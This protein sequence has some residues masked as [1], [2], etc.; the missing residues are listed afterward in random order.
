M[1]ARLLLLFALL[2]AAAGCTDNSDSDA[3]GSDG[4]DDARRAALATYARIAHAS[5][6]DALAGAE[7]LDRAVDA[8]LAAPTAGGLQTAR[9]AWRAAREP[10]G[11]TEAF[12]F[13]G[14]PIDAAGGPE[15]LLNAWPLDEAYVDYVVGAPDAG[16]I[17]RPDLYPEIDA[18]L[19]D[20]LNERGSE[21]NVSAG[22]HAVE[23]LLWG[24]DLRADGPGD[25]PFTDYT[26]AP[27]ADRRAQYLAAA[28]DQLLVHLQTMVTAWRPDDPANYRA[29]FLAQD[30][31]LSLRAVLMGIETLAA[32]EL[33]VER[34][35]V[36]LNNQDQEDEQSCFSDH[37]QRDIAANAQGIANVYR[38]RYVRLDGNVVEGPSLAALV[39]AADAERARLVDA[40][41]DS[42]LRLTTDLPAPFDRALVEQPDAVLAVVDA[43]QDLGEQLGGAAQALGFPAP[44]AS[45]SQAVR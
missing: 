42:A 27:H 8:F 32:S 38:G 23:F 34:I 36:A 31:D 7:A 14:G 19:L 28:T 39:R 35:F 5:Y 21:E 26:T 37:T 29:A 18:A 4:P 30:P 45:H 33:A 24:Q 3:G 2:L 22:Y 25:R 1:R 40:A 6:A 11:Q 43:L 44:T 17:A 16:L 10:Y 15:P 41:L 9:D 20:S 13:S 12:R